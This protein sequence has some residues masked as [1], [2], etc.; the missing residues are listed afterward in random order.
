MLQQQQQQQKHQLNEIYETYVC[1]CVCAIFF[2]AQFR[3]NDIA[4]SV[5]VQRFFLQRRTFMFKLF[6][7]KKLQQIRFVYLK[8]LFEMK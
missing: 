6:C 8:S 2:R 3:F 5:C 7:E 4:I 1:I